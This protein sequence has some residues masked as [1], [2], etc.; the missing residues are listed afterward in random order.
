MPIPRSIAGRARQCAS[1]DPTTTCRCADPCGATSLAPGADEVVQ[2]PGVEPP[3]LRVLP[4]LGFVRQT[5]VAKP[6]NGRT[7]VWGQRDFNRGRSRRDRRMALPA[8]T[9]HQPPRRVDFLVFAARDVLAVDVDAV[10]AARPGVELGPAAHPARKTPAVGQV[11]EHD[12]R[13]GVDPLRDLDRAGEV[14][15]HSGASLVPPPRP[16]A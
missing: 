9:H 2:P 1:W 16:A 3:A 8:P 12:L 11:G 5:E 6:E 14:L 4:T 7:L 13:R 10:T 15:N